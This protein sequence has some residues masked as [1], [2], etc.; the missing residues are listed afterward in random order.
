MQIWITG[1]VTGLLT[2]VIILG[3]I[4]PWADPGDSLID[5]WR[6]NQERRFYYGG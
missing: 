1:I 3:C 2:G 6:M 5:T 4:P